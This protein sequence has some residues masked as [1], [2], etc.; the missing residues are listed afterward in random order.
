MFPTVDPM[1]SCLKVLHNGTRLHRSNDLPPSDGST[2]AIRWFAPPRK[3]PLETMEACLLVRVQSL[4]TSLVV[5][6]FR[7]VS[8]SRFF[9]GVVVVFLRLDVERPVPDVV[10]DLSLEPVGLDLDRE[11]V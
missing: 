9:V 7:F 8:F 4:R 6:S 5:V 2:M 10:L 3:R 1:H 11:F